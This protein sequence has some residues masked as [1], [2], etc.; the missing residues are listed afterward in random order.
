[1]VK[2]DAANCAGSGAIQGMGT[3]A[4]PES[5]PGVPKGKKKLS[6]ILANAKMLRRKP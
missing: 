5:E 1:M 6:V 2:E 4:Y 3:G